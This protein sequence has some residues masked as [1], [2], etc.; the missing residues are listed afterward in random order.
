MPLDDDDI[1]RVMRDVWNWLPTFRAVAET[2]HLP[3]AAQRLHVTPAAISRTVGLLEERLGKPLFNRT[4]RTLVLNESGRELLQRL[5]SGM[6]NV[7][8]GLRRATRPPLSGP[9]RISSLGLLTNY[10][11]LPAVLDLVDEHEDLE[12]ILS[13]R[14]TRE[15]AEAL[16]QGKVDVALFYET[17]TFEGV[18]IE[19]FGETSASIYCGRGHPLFEAL[20]AGEEVPFERILEHPFSVPGI[21]DTGKVMDDWPSDIPRE[22]GM[23]IMLLTSNLEV[24]RSGRF[25]T[26]LPDITAREALQAG[27]IRRFPYDVIPP[28]HLYAARRQTDDETGRAALVIEAIRRRAREV[29]EM[30]SDLDWED[31]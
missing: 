15:A 30:L 19:K 26:V 8:R 1:D 21:G 24:C 13:N 3:T 6:E 20:E 22:I 12:P 11:A 2:E 4:G 31:V 27:E 16:L 10:F 5:R 7:E 25:V 17:M 14:R 23:R 9:V 28:T 18:S 29:E